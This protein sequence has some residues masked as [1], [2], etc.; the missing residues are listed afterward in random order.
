MDW[1][2]CQEEA[3][4]IKIYA[5]KERAISLMKSARNMMEF[6]INIELN[7]KNAS[8]LLKNAYE[9]LL[10]LLHALLYSKG[11][12]VLNHVCVGY[13]IRDELKDAEAF[14]IFDKYRKIRNSIVYYGESV[15]REV[16]EEAIKEIKGLFDKIEKII[17][18]GRK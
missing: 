17:E 15:E 9:S 3:N 12:K 13:F 8:I 10:E 2:Q 16:A 7:D 1:K 5:N 4:A 18:K 6:V 14:Y 11:Y